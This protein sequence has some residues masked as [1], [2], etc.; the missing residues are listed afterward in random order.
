MWE[1]FRE[2]IYMIFL[3]PHSSHVLQPLDVGA[4]S[5]LKRAYRK[6]LGNLVALTNTNPVG[7]LNFLRYYKEA[8]DKALTDKNI[9]GGFRGTRI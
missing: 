1:C 8:R 2:N 6:H 7:K 4:F 9:K 3:P 5:A